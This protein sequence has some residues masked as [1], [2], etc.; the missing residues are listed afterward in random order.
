MV[1]AGGKLKGVKE[2]KRI[3]MKCPICDKGTLKKQ[4]VDI[5][6]KQFKAEACNACGEQIFDS[7][8]A[9]K[10]EEIIRKK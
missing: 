9:A 8:Q 6:G 3:G 5:R 7:R 2:G 10:I 4:T 1:G